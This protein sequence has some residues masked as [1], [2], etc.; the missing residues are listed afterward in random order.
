MDW[1][2]FGSTL[3]LAAVTVALVWFTR[4]LAIE[5]LHTRDE[6]KLA[7]A[8]SEASRLQSVRPRLALGVDNLGAG[9]GFISISNV[10]QGGAIDVRATLTFEGLAESRRISFHLIPVGGSREQQFMTPRN[11]DGEL[12]RMDDLCA[13]CECVSLVGSMADALGRRHEIDETIEI[14]AVWKDTVESSR[15]LPPDYERENH[16]EIEKIR[17]ALEQLA[18]T[19]RDEHR[20]LWS[21]PEGPGEGS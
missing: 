16:A 2:V 8:E 4:R 1:A 11:A 12:M 10:G 14:A 6:M 13:R 15:R 19:A 7:R 17:R 9:L 21:S 20:R 5:A 3:V 18:H